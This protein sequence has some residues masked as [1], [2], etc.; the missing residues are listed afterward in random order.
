MNELTASKLAHAPKS[1]SNNALS[2]LLKRVERIVLSNGLTLLLLEDHHAPV[3]TVQFWTKTGSRNEHP[4]TTGISHLFEHMMFRGSTKYGPEQHANLV[5]RY[6]GV[7]NA[8]TSFDHTVYY[9]TI[10][11]DQLE[12]I[13][14]LEAERFANLKLD[15][16]VLREEKKVVAEERRMR[17]DNSVTGSAQ[18]QLIVN[19]YRSAPYHWPIIGWMSDIQNYSLSDIHEY[20][21]LHYAPNN[22]VGVI[23]G[24]FESDKAVKLVKKYWGKIPSQPTPPAPN[25]DEIPQRGERRIIHKYPTELPLLYASFR[26]PPFDHPDLPALEIVSRALSHGQSCRLFQ[27]LVYKDQT[28]RYALG[29]L[30]PLVG[31]GLFIFLV[32]LQPEAPLEKVENSL[33][34]E[35]ERIRN[36]GISVEELEKAKNQLETEQIGELETTSGIASLLGHFEADG[37]DYK[38]STLYLDRIRKVKNEDVLRVAKEYMQADGRTVVTVIPEMNGN[39]GAK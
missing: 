39:G 17:Y 24:D 18:E 32:A 36:E 30:L 2:S 35:V 34:E 21:R 8:Y 33:W 25:M 19:S 20:Y 37:G 26:I 3:V 4:G 22:V 27:R 16:N 28:A 38:K 11:S 31:P 12:L 10:A 23:V 5:K 13:I 6:G 15:P 29:E 7:L 14:H 9:E 1:G